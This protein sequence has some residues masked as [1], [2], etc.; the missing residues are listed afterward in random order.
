MQTLQESAEGTEI[1]N[2]CRSLTTSS[3]PSAPWLLD[4]GFSGL[5]F[6][7]STDRASG[8]KH[9]GETSGRNPSQGPSSH[10]ASKSV[11]LSE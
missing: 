7:P 4:T 3:S 5:R 1:A 11:P 9:R 2:V 10:L 8:T 6:L